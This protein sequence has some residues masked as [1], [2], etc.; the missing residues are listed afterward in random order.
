LTASEKDEIKKNLSFSVKQKFRQQ[1]YEAWFLDIRYQ[2]AQDSN[3]CVG[4]ANN[5]GTDLNIW[6]LQ[7]WRSPEEPRSLSPMRKHK[8]VS[9]RPQRLAYGPGRASYVSVKLR[10]LPTINI[11]A[12]Y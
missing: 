12:E 7:R 4:R 11:S 6:K 9:W 1:I 8:Q 10:V 2:S 3:S 5:T